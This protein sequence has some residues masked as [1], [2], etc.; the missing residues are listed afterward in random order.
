MSPEKAFEVIAKDQ[1]MLQTVIF[2]LLDRQEK[3]KKERLYNIHGVPGTYEYK[4]V[5]QL[6]EQIELTEKV[7]NLFK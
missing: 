3:L 4:V 7:Y 6:D 1:D 2:A 5:S